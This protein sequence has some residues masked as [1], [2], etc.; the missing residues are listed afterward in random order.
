MKRPD[1]PKGVAAYF[2]RGQYMIDQDEKM[3]QTEFYPDTVCLLV[4]AEGPNNNKLPSTVSKWEILS[5]GI[6]F[7]SPNDDFDKPDYEKAEVIAMGRA[8]KTYNKS[9]SRITNLEFIGMIDK[10][11]KNNPYPALVLS[12]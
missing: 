7:F 10:A 4:K 11:K 12:A 3:Y 6:A 9:H 5:S 1:L 8:L 2:V